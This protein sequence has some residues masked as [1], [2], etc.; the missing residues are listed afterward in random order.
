MTG[1]ELSREEQ[2]WQRERAKQAEYERRMRERGR[3]RALDAARHEARR[4]SRS[5]GP[6]DFDDISPA[7][8]ALPEAH[9]AFREHA[10]G[11]VVAVEGDPAFLWAGPAGLE[12][13]PALDRPGT[14]L[15]WADLAEVTV[16]GA[17]MIQERVTAGRFVA[18]GFLAFAVPKREG[19]SY[20]LIEPRDGAPILCEAEGV[21]APDLRGIVLRHRPREAAAAASPDLAAVEALERLAALHSTGALT[22]EEFA[23][24]K[25]KVLGA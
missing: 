18:L 20:A 3:E 10:R 19:A 1:T 8:D 16:D 25:A 12:V 23:A 14:M 22:P 7:L 17:A 9:R 13:A 15:A 24:A 5:S 21:S 11:L 6:V 2:R 4:A